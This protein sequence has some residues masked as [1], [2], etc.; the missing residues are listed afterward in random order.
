MSTKTPALFWWSSSRQMDLVDEG[1]GQVGLQPGPR[2]A[3]LWVSPR[4]GLSDTIR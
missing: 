3:R 2:V 4:A 1:S